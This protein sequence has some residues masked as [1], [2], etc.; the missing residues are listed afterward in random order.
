M[1][2]VTIM[3]SS[4]RASAAGAA[5]GRPQSNS[6]LQAACDDFM[7]GLWSTSDD[8]PVTPARV[9]GRGLRPAE[10]RTQLQATLQPYRPAIA[11]DRIGTGIAVGRI[12]L[13]RH[14]LAGTRGIG[15]PL[16]VLRQGLPG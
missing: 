4:T 6:R 1:V 8:E 9:Q 16:T 12:E 15:L 14:R 5:I 11:R 10:R 2:P 7:Q 3:P 13:P